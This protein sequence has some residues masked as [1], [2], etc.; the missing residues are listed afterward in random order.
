[1]G[2][3]NIPLYTKVCINLTNTLSNRSLTKIRSYACFT[4]IY[5]CV[6]NVVSQNN[7]L[8]FFMIVWFFWCH[9]N[10]A[11]DLVGLEGPKRP[12]SR[13]WWCLVLLHVASTTFLTDLR[14]AFREAE[15]EAAR[16]L[17]PQ[18]H[19][20]H[21]VRFPVS[22]TK[23]RGQCRFQGWGNRSYPLR[24]ATHIERVRHT[25]RKSVATLTI[26]YK[27]VW[28]HFYKVE[29]VCGYKSLIRCARRV[30][31]GRPLRFLDILCFFF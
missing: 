10:V 9:L 3:N 14:A 29:P 8:L 11:A 23:W 18:P 4:W 20:L 25:G 16:P 30:V 28:C 7:V 27:T 12:H 6:T 21:S 22:Q 2:R 1:M 24:R 13:I 26:Y 31:W 5:C 19:K 17:K 15:S